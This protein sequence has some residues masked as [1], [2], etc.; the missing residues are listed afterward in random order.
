MWN[1][2]FSYFILDTII[3]EIQR[4]VFYRFF[5][6]FNKIKLSIT[7]TNICLLSKKDCN[8]TATKSIHVV[9]ST[10]YGYW[11]TLMT[12]WI[13]LILVLILEMIICPSID[14]NSLQTIPLENASTRWKKS[15]LQIYSFRSW[16]NLFLS[17]ARKK[18][19]FATQ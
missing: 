14:L 7:M 11:N 12:F 16:I 17:E 1:I 15:T 3:P 8:H 18:T 10:Q 4:K 13:I 6:L 2:C 5:Y 9:A 19:K